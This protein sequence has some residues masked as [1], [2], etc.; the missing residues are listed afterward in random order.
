[1]EKWVLSFLYFEFYSG[2]GHSAITICELCCVS[3]SFSLP[4]QDAITGKCVATEPAFSWYSGNHQH[5]HGDT[6]EN[7]YFSSS[8]A[9][10]LQ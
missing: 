5:G 8:I 3:K 7:F 9:L 1:M 10:L 2:F 4:F 6:G